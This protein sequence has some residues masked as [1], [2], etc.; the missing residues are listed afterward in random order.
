MCGQTTAAQASLSA[1]QGMTIQE[2]SEAFLRGKKQLASRGGKHHSV[3]RHGLAADAARVMAINLKQERGDGLSPGK[4]MKVMTQ[5]MPG[6]VS[7][8]KREPGE[9]KE[10]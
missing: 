10:N 4:F 2:A 7:S 1:S 6:R 5:P 8:V 3:R 9:G